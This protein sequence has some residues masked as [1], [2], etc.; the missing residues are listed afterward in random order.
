MK[1]IV[2]KRVYKEY[3]KLPK[4]VK[5][6]AI[7]QMEA[8]KAATSLSD[9]ENIR[10]LKGTDE[11]YYRLSFNDYRFVLYHHVETDTIEVVSLTHRKDTYKKQNLPWH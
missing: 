4:H 3:D 8:L 7:K 6:M 1:N 2:A 5:S 10:P 9:I 11:P